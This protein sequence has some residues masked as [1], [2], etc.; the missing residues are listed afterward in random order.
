MLKQGA[1]YVNGRRAQGERRI[2]RDDT[3]PSGVIV[4]RRG[5]RDYLLVRVV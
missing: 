1:L 3:L 4:L 5:K 2:T